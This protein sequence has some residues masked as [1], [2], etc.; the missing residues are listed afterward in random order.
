MSKLA[1]SHRILGAP[2]QPAK[3]EDVR[4]VVRDIEVVYNQLTAAP[5]VTG[6]R[7]GGTALRNLLTALADLGLI[8][9]NTTA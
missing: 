9:D 3:A 1:V 2:D 7:A 4:R 5:S 8:T 6:S